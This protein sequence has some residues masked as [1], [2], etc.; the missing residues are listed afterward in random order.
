MFEDRAIFLP[1]S[2]LFCSVEERVVGFPY[3]GLRATGAS[4]FID[5]SRVAEQR[6]SI[7]VGGEEC[8]FRG[9]GTYLEFDIL[10][11]FE[12]LHESSFAS[13]YDRFRLLTVVR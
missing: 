11:S 3:V 4:I 5:Y 12:Q 10:I 2:V 8:D 13:F 6:N 1:P 9:L 7:F